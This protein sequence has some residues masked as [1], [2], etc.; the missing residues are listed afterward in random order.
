MESERSQGGVKREREGQEGKG[1]VRVWESEDIH[2]NGTVL[3]RSASFAVALYAHKHHGL[4]R[5]QCAVCM[6][7]TT[8]HLRIQRPSPPEA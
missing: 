4:E 5:V 3:L 8:S 7:F 2:P 6:R 1:A